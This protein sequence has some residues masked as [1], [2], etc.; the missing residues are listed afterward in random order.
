MVRQELVFGAELVGFADVR[1]V[2]AG[3]EDLTLVDLHYALQSAF[4][5]DDA[6]LGGFGP[7]D[8]FGTNATDPSPRPC[9]DEPPGPDERSA[10][11]RLD[12]LGLAEGQ[13]LAYVFD[14]GD[15]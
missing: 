14:F 12:S 15:E 3:R 13:Q 4:G 1:R 5:W 8:D 9:G 10:A 2:I 6:P 7:C 11:I